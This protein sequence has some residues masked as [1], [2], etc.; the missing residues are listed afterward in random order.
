MKYLSILYFLL[1]ASICHSQFSGL[2]PITNTANG[3]R[4]IDAA[5][6]DGDGFND[7]IAANRFGSNVTWYKNVDAGESF[8]SNEIAFLNQASMVTH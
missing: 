4:W 1:H 7:I 8:V 5:D 2:K 6:I 3:V